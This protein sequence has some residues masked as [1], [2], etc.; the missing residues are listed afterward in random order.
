MKKVC[1]AWIRSIFRANYGDFL[2]TDYKCR[3]ILIFFAMCDNDYAIIC[4]DYATVSSLPH[5]SILMLKEAVVHRC[6]S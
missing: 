5:M 3:K 6:S 4:Y 1:F 2:S